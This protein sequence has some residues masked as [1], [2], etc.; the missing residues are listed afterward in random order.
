MGSA[1]RVVHANNG[2]VPVNAGAWFQPLTIAD[3]ANKFRRVLKKAADPRSLTV[4]APRFGAASVLRR[5]SAG[6]QAR[7]VAL[8]AD[9]QWT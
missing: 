5:F 1:V 2:G 8:I 6:S 4:A 9:C 3:W 7:R